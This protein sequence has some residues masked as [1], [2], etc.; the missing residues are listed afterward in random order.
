MESLREDFVFGK[1]LFSTFGAGDMISWDNLREKMYGI[2][3]KTYVFSFS[4]DTYNPRLWAY[5]SIAPVRGGKLKELPL[6]ALYLESK[7][8]PDEK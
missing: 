8:K 2:I 5:A 4:N 7:Y 1:S 6:N 3:L